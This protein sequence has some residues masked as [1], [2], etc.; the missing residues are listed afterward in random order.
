MHDPRWILV[1][2]GV[3]ALAAAL[4]FWRMTQPFRAGLTT[5]N[6]LGS[7]DLDQARA[8]LERSWRAGERRGTS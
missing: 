3:V 2:W 8:S 7:T 6:R 4:R 5:Q 1:A